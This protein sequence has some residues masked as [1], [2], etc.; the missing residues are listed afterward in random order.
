[1]TSSAPCIIRVNVPDRVSEHQPRGGGAEDDHPEHRLV[2][3]ALGG[4]ARIPASLLAV[5]LERNHTPISAEA[6]LVGASF[7][8]IESPTGGERQLPHVWNK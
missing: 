5:A 3:D 1:M 8:T 4:P 6:N 2:A 7:V